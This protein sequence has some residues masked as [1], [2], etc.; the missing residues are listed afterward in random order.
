MMLPFVDKY[1]GDR[2]LSYGQEMTFQLRHIGGDPSLTVEDVILMGSGLT[3][4]APIIAQDN[5]TPGVIPQKYTFRL[6]LDSNLII[7]CR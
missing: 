7:S 6:V 5:P 3:I 4:S 2:R 1:L